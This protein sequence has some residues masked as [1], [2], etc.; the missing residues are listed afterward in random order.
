MQRHFWQHNAR[1]NAAHDIIILSLI[2]KWKSQVSRYVAYV[3]VTRQTLF[4]FLLINFCLSYIVLFVEWGKLNWILHVLP[5]CKTLTKKK[6]EKTEAAVSVRLCNKKLPQ[7]IP[8]LDWVE[9]TFNHIW[10][11]WTN[12]QG[13]KSGDTTPQVLDSLETNLQP[14]GRRRLPDVCQKKEC[15]LNKLQVVVVTTTA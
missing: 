7:L 5:L 4:T 10:G 15:Y 9:F 3:A 13:S 6:H 12:L 1:C 8:N 11:K 14:S 2:V